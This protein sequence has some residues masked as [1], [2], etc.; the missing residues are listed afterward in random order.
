MAIRSVLQTTAF[1]ALVEPLVK[2]KNN[3]VSPAGSC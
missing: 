2:S 3:D 1:G